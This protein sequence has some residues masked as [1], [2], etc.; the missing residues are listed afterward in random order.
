MGTDVLSDA[1]F[2]SLVR[3][4]TLR[5]LDAARVAWPAS[6]RIAG[7]A[8]NC[9]A[10]WGDLHISLTFLPE[11]AAM[12]PPDWEHEVVDAELPVLAELWR[13]RYEP[14]RLRHEAECAT[15]PALADVFLDRL[16][17]VLVALE[18]D[19]AFAAH[20]GIRLLVTEVDADTEAEQAAL[21]HVRAQPA[22]EN[23]A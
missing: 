1:G 13:Q 18:R 5:A 15:Q 16:R 3:E 19:G 4:L 9:S 11:R 12:E 6:S 14:L 2:E 8:Y 10:A 22:M 20:P 23:G 21:A 17:R 7:F